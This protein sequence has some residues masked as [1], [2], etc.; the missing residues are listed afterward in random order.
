LSGFDAEIT[1]QDRAL[2]DAAD[3]GDVG[4]GFVGGNDRAIAGRSA[5]DFH[6]RALIDTAA[7]GAIVDVHLADGD[8]DAGRQAELF[9]P[10][11]AEISGDGG[12]VVGLGEE[13]VAERGELGIEGG[14]EFL[15]GQA[16]PVLGVKRLVPG[17]AD[18]A[19][20]L[21]GIGDSG[22]HGRNEIGELD[23][24]IGGVEHN[25]IDLEAV[26]DFRPEPLGRVG[27]ADFREVLRAEFSGDFGDGSGFGNA[28]VVL[29]EPALGVE[30]SRKSRGVGER[31]VCLIDRQRAGA[32]A[33]HADADDLVIR[34]FRLGGAGSLEG[35]Q[36]R[37]FEGENVVRRALA[38]EVVIGGFQED[39]LISRGII[40]HRGADFAT[41]GAID[42]EGAG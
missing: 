9:R 8:R 38:G 6:Q 28:G 7:D 19:A 21:A 31:F 33:V 3:P 13:A 10:C 27:A 5:D 4:D 30:V 42:D 32:G 14:E 23:P 24:G 1:G 35:E 11:G 40:D 2:D 34:K 37:F 26:P 22:E 25:G 12:G 17:H 29:P 39:S 15:V 18:A 41:V 16:A 36:S 20:D